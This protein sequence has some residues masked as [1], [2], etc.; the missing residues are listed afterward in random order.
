MEIS[1]VKREYQLQQWSKMVQERSESGLTVKDWCEA[2]GLTEYTY[3][4]RLRKIRQAA[5]NVLEQAQSVPSAQLAELP[6]TPK[7]DGTF[8]KLRLTTKS[9]VLELMDADSSVLDQ[10]LRVMLHAE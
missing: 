4:Y 10:I 7:S 2:R 5:C 3:Y 6:L 9:G 1:E 8:A